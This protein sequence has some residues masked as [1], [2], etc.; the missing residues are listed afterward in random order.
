MNDAYRKCER[1]Q[2]SVAETVSADAMYAP[3]W[4]LTASDSRQEVDLHGNSRGTTFTHRLCTHSA[5]SRRFRFRAIQFRSKSLKITTV[6]RN[7]VPTILVLMRFARPLALTHASIYHLHYP[8]RPFDWS[9]TRS[10]AIY[11]VASTSPSPAPHCRPRE[12][13]LIWEKRCGRSMHDARV[14]SVCS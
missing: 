11:I 5:G 6:F 8:S 3:R 10:A 2:M 13:P 14:A 1:R 12:I 4:M 9:I 7:A